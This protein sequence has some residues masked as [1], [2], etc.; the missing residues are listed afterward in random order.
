MPFASYRAAAAA[1]LAS[2]IAT[3]LALAQD[4]VPV[5]VASPRSARIT[6]ELRLTGTLTADRSARLSP[7]VDGLVARVRVD[8]GDRVAAGAPLLELDAAVATLALERARA[9]TAEARARSEEATRLALEAQRLV[10]DR[11]L[12]QTEL[13]RREADAKLA[14]ASL[15]ASKASEREY[16]ELLRRHTLRAPFSGVVARRLT[17]VGEWVARGTPVLELVALDR[18]RLDVQAP[19]ERFASIREDASVRVY[20]DSLRGDSLPGRIV[21]RVP[22]SDPTARTFLVRVLVDDGSDQ[23]L[24]GTSATAVIGLPGS[25]DA[26]VVPRDALLRYPDGT[27]SVFAVRD[28]EGRSTAVERPVKLGRSGT[29]AEILEGIE[30][31][32]RVVVR[33]NERLRS[34]Q[35]VRIVEGG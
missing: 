29:E 27:Y 14:A 11:H 17:D 25:K 24:P 3:D 12:P 28:V 16:A 34:G 31:G 20:S 21:A 10:A 1:C 15:A 19:Q 35:A 13:A 2:L 9:G 6:E 22:V 8:A 4:A 32:D 30:P 33:G 7:R 5:V 18:V 26:L 23:L